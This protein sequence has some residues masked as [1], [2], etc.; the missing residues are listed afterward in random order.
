MKIKSVKRNEQDIYKYEQH[1]FMS[2][3][4]LGFLSIG[5]LFI[6]SMSSGNFK[7]SIS[8]VLSALC[9]PKENL[10]VYRIITQSRLPRLVASLLVGAALSS[11]GWVYQE[12]FNNRMASPDILGVSAGAGCGASIA[13]LLGYA[14][15]ITSIFAFVGGLLAVSITIILSSSFMKKGGN[16]I[17]LILSG[18]VMSGLLNSL[19]GMI[20]YVANDTQLSTITFWLLGGFYSITW[21]QLLICS[22]IICS[23]LIILYLF[24]WKIVIL[25][26]GEDDA[27]IH[28]IAPRTI[29]MWCIVI[30][31]IVTSAA[32]CMSG[33][34]GWIGLAIP[35]LI[36]LLV[37][38]DGKHLFPLSVVYGALFMEICDLVARCTT[39]TEIPV[40]I[41][42]GLL[43][44]FLFIA[45]IASEKTRRK[46][47]NDSN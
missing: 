3:M 10:M 44:A 16:S 26:H 45:V 17:P 20:K 36:R 14:F 37:Q 7:T 13:I 21:N 35:N 38:D 33:T 41:I 11:A 40:G 8:D 23:G 34:I 43:G 1:R 46:I 47:R 29:K 9:H 4:L 28:G 22:P 6:V 42:S 12:L 39:N 32:V 27:A 5:V 2:L 31:T 25:R 30:A 18:I 15:S 24:R 19:M